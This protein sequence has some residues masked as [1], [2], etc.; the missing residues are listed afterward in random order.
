M[1]FSFWFYFECCNWICIS[2]SCY[3]LFLFLI[4]CEKIH[5]FYLF[6]NY[7]PKQDVCLPVLFPFILFS[8]LLWRTAKGLIGFVSFR[9]EVFCFLFC[10]QRWLI[11]IFVHVVYMFHFLMEFFVASL[12]LYVVALL[13][14]FAELRELLLQID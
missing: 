11:V 12:N 1:F 6:E 14:L 13:V 10:H 3:Q 2:Y 8:L 7:L 9:F 5:V 4:F